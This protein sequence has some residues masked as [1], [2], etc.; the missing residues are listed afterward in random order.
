MLNNKIKNIIFDLGGV[1]VNLDRNRCMHNFYQ[2]GFHNIEEL[3]DPFEQEGI[4]MQLEKGAISTEEFR[5]KIREHT[6]TSLSN[7]QIDAAWNS[8]LVDFP[9][10]KLDKLLELRSKYKLY[11]LSNTNEIHWQW[12][13]SNGF[14]YK[15]YTVKDYFE[16]TFLSFEMHKTKPGT[17]I[18]QEVLNETDIIPDETFFIDDSPAN[19]ET[20]EI[21]GISTYTPT[22]G[23]DWR[24][25]F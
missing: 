4:F 15:G 1:I 2:L 17:A 14:S 22:P 3:I 10:Y 24:H 7:T 11:L 12:C 6:N 16:K 18:F 19:C 8:F 5:D 25:L 21:L 9:T 20:A 13:L 23:E